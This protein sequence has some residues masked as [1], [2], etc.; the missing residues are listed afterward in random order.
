MTLFSQAFISRKIDV[1]FRSH[2]SLEFCF[3]TNGK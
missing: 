2:K 1:E 3:L